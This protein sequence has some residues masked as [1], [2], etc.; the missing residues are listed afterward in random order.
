ML[1]DLSDDNLATIVRHLQLLRDVVL[2]A[3]TC[4]RHAT[5]LRPTI[6]LVRDRPAVAAQ[7]LQVDHLRKEVEIRGRQVDSSDVGE[8]VRLSAVLA[9]LR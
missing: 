8:L 2:F 5:L 6:N 4:T 3:R 1:A 9:V 7:R